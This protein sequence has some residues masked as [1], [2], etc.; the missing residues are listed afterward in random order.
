MQ[1]DTYLKFIHIC[2][3]AFFSDDHKLNI[4]GIFEKISTTGYPLLFPKFSIVTGINSNEG[5]HTEEIKIF[6]KGSA[7]P[8]AVATGEIS[9]IK[10]LAGANFVANF[11][12]IVFRDKGDYV[13]EVFLDG[14]KINQERQT[15]ISL[16]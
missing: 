9:I 1:K 4:I 12:G 5:V 7:D 8:T 10:G 16:I 14:E 6:K 2:E 13:I 15:I 3:M 11:V